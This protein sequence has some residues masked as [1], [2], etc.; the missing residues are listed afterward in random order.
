MTPLLTLDTDQ[1]DVDINN[2]VVHAS[3]FKLF[4]GS[5]DHEST[6]WR[7]ERTDG[8]VIWE[9]TNDTD[10]K[11][12]IKIPQLVLSYRRAYVIKAMYHTNTGASSNYGSILI[13]TTTPTPV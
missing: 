1:N 2:C 10:N 12:S 8:K 6:T 3:D 7:I 4:A 11:L 9:R 5:S 13:S